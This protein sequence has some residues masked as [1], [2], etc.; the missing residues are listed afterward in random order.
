MGRPPLSKGE[1]EVAKAVWRV[2]KGTVSE[3]HAAVSEELKMDY[4]TVQTYIR[5]L[6]TKGYLKAERIGRNKVYR[7]RVKRTQVMREA[8]DEFVDRLFDGELLP[9]MKHLLRDRDVSDAEIEHLRQLVDK[10]QEDKNE[11]RD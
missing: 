3:I 8:I 11:S 1:T 4:S 5:R 9:M 6:E 10:L 7:S 2:K